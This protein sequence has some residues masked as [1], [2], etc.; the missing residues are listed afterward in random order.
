MM[1]VLTGTDVLKLS[2]GK[3]TVTGNGGGKDGVGVGVG[4]GGGLAVGLTEG[5][6]VGIGIPV[7]VM[8]PL[9]WLGETAFKSASMNSK[10]L[11]NGLQAKELVVPGTLLTLNILRL[12]SA[13]DPFNGVTPSFENAEIRTVFIVPGP[14][15]ITVDPTVQ[16]LAVS[17]AAWAGAF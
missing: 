9:F 7:M 3:L 14:E 10:S 8:R 13:P 4:V 12:N 6:G 1:T 16:P 2:V 17:P 5:V 11:G 15:L